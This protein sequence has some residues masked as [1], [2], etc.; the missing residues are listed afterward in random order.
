MRARA[1]TAH[2][3][4]H[5][6]RRSAWGCLVLPSGGEGE[7]LLLA[8]PLEDG[9]AHRR[10]PD[11]PAPPLEETLAWKAQIAAATE[12]A[13]R[14]ILAN[15]HGTRMDVCRT[16]GLTLLDHADWRMRCA[17]KAARAQ[18]SS[19]P[20]SLEH[21]LKVLA[22]MA[23]RSAKAERGSAPSAIG[24]GGWLNPATGQDQ[25]SVRVPGPGQH[26]LVVPNPALEQGEARTLAERTIREWEQRE[27]QPRSEEEREQDVALLIKRLGRA[28]GII[29][30]DT[31]DEPQV[32]DAHTIAE[33]LGR[34]PAGE[35]WIMLYLTPKGKRMLRIWYGASVQILK[36]RRLKPGVEALADTTQRLKMLKGSMPEATYAAVLARCTAMVEDHGWN[37]ERVQGRLLVQGGQALREFEGPRPGTEEGGI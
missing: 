3:S 16:L 21:E 26:R 6:T 24:Q 36:L 11:D 15:G 13:R 18:R 22:D 5:T 1:F 19:I 10:G 14:G 29:G 30:W 8:G 4:H 27:G 12:L 2:S 31:S 7:P 9:P 35:A 20:E 23:A 37:G 25:A 33:E 28:G 34:W 32:Q 17:R